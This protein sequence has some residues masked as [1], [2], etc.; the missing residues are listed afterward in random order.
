MDRINLFK[1][2]WDRADKG[3]L[4]AS[5]IGMRALAL[6]RKLHFYKEFCGRN[7][8]SKLE[9]KLL[10]QIHTGSKQFLDAL[11]KAK[12][13]REKRRGR[14]MTEED[15]QRADFTA[16]GIMRRLFGIENDKTWK[17]LLAEM[18]PDWKDDPRNFQKF[19]RET[20][21]PFQP[22]GQWRGPRKC[23]RKR[24]KNIH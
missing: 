1:K 16:Y 5:E 2:K 21:N 11:S 23:V 7:R 9:A 4:G 8:S 6:L 17:D 18:A 19:L 15:A 10:A 12:A 13:F 22:A 24:G 3:D 20:L 14:G